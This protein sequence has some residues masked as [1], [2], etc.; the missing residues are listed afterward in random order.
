MAYYDNNFTNKAIFQE[1]MQRKYM[2][3][4]LLPITRIFP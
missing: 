4:T 3:G 1:I 2:Y